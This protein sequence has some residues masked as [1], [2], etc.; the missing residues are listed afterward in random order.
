ML[1]LVF[2]EARIRK[3]VPSLQALIISVRPLADLLLVSVAQ[4]L[5]R[6]PR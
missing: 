5:K 2:M 3:K 6:S 1:E 4:N